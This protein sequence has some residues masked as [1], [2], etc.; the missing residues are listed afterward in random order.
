[1]RKYLFSLLA[2]GLAA[3]S[4]NS[5]K[6]K[7]KEVSGVVTEVAMS[8]DY[9]SD[10][11]HTMRIFN[12]EDTLLFSLKDAQYNNGVMLKGD[13]VQVGYIKGKGDTLR[14]LLV[15]VKPAPAKVIN[16]EV[17]TTKEVMTR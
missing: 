10:T 15:Y 5:C 12:G 13:S 14:A 1:M 7:L 9:Q 17:D 16:I 8:G 2:L 3:C 11:I 6:Q 4:L